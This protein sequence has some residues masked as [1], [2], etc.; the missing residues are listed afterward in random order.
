MGEHYFINPSKDDKKANERLK[1][2]LGRSFAR[3]WKKK[4]IFD[5]VMATVLLLAA[6]AALMYQCIL[7]LERALKEHFGVIV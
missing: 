2:L 6:A 1:G 7:W 4:R 3:Y 5:L